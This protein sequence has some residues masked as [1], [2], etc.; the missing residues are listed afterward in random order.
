MMTSFAVRKRSIFN[1]IK[2]QMH[3]AAAFCG[4]FI[5][6][7]SSSLYLYAR[8]IGEQRI[9]IGA[10]YGILF[11]LLLSSM[12]TDSAGKFLVDAAHHPAAKVIWIG[13]VI[14]PAL[15]F[16][17]VGGMNLLLESGS[18][19][20]ERDIDAL[21][22]SLALFGTIWAGGI[23]IISTLWIMLSLRDIFDEGTMPGVSSS[24]E[25]FRLS[26][27]RSGMIRGSTVKLD[28]LNTEIDDAELEKWFLFKSIRG[29]KLM[30]FVGLLAEFLVLLLAVTSRE[31]FLLGITATV[32]TFQQV[33][34]LF[35]GD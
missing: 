12:I 16:M 7:F 8:S 25:E 31:A 17:F 27:L 15:L 4:I 23:D 14:I 32:L 20:F 35:T 24:Q 21:F 11:G 2:P 18:A 26:L 9:E 22:I 19:S 29:I 10:L 3:T 13:L 33:T 34:L 5:V 6:I 30:L 28:I 1:V